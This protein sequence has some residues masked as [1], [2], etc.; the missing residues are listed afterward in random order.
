MTRHSANERGQLD[1]VTVAEAAAFLLINVGAVLQVRS[2][3][4]D[5]GDV[6]CGGSDRAEYA[7]SHTDG[8]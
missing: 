4:A 2:V 8:C 7:S 1:L 3:D 5:G 6:G